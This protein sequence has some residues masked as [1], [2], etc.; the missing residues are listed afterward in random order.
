[1]PRRRFDGS[2]AMANYSS[3]RWQAVCG[4]LP[5]GEQK[6]DKARFV[7]SNK[8][9]PRWIV[10]PIEFD[11]REQ[12]FDVRVPCRRVIITLDACIEHTYY[13]RV[14]LSNL[15][16]LEQLPTLSSLACYYT[17]SRPKYSDERGDVQ[18]DPWISC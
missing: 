8:A 4:G 17:P 13:R 9:A 14:V 11:D 7:F 6:S 10:E 18:G 15:A 16:Y 1:M 12:A 2:T 5:L 3:A